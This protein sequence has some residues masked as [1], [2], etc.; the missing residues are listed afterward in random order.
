M[1]L[2]LTTP[3]KISLYL[4]QLT[5]STVAM[6]RVPSRLLGKISIF[7]P[8]K[9]QEMANTRSVVTQVVEQFTVS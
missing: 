7:Q 8:L 3:M 9:Q 5:L 4:Q 2:F 1:F 6:R